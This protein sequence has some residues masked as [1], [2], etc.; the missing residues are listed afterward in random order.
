MKQLTRFSVNYPVTIL[1]L[2]LAI[3]LLGYISFTKIGI[4]LFPDLNN[5]KLYIE[6]SAGERPPEEME[7]LFVEGIESQAIRQSDVTEVSSVTSVGYSLVTIEYSWNK[8]M[9]EAFLDL[10]KAVNAFSQSN[11][12]DEINISQ[13]DPNATPVMVVALE[14]DSISDLNEIRKVADNYIKNELIRLEGVADV[15]LVGEQ[16]SEVVIETNPY[17]LDAFNLTA[18]TISSQIAAYNTNVSG[19]SIEE[20]GTRYSIK[21]LSMISGPDDLRQI[22]VGTY[23]EQLED[24]TTGEI[25]PIYLSDVATIKVVNKDPDSYVRYNG[26]NCIGLSIYKE[27]KFNTVKAVDELKEELRTIEKALPGYKLASVKDQGSFIDESIMEVRDSALYGIILAVIVIFAFLGQIRPT[28]VISIAIPISIVATFV[29]MY[30]LGLSFNIMTLGGLALGAGML[31]DNAIIV[32]ENIYRHMEKGKSVMKAAIK[33]TS[34]VAGAIT[35]STLTTIVVFLPIVYIHGASGELFK[36]QAWTVAFSL[37]SSLFVAILVMPVLVT[38]IF[39]K[40]AKVKRETVQVRGYRKLLEKVLQ[41]RFAVVIVAV[42]LV[43]VSYFLLPRIGSEFMPTSASNSFT[44]DIKLPQGTVLHKTSATTK[45]IEDI[46]KQALPE[47]IE[48]IYT[49]NGISSNS[50]TQ[51]TTSSENEATIFVRLTNL[52]EHQYASVLKNVDALIAQNDEIEFTFEKDETSLQT[53]LGNSDAPVV[54]EVIGDELD[55]ISTITEQTKEIVASTPGLYNIETSIEDGAPEIDVEI[56][57]VR[58]GIYGININTIITQVQNRLEGTDAG[59]FEEDGE[60]KS[61]TIKQPKVSIHELEN[62]EITNANSVYRLTDLATIHYNN[63][64]R[65]IHRRNQNRIGKITASTD[66]SLPLDQ[67]VKELNEKL[68]SVPLP[69][70][71]RYEI[72]GEEVKREESMSNLTF[73]LVLAIILVYMVM[74]AQFE[75]LMNPFVILLTIPLALVGVVFIFLIIGKP[76]NIMAFIGMIML[77]GIAVNDSII[78]IDAINKLRA[79]GLAK[80]EAILQAGQQRIRPIIMTSLTTILALIPLTLGFGSGASLRSPMAWAVIGGLVTSTL[81]TLV[82]IPAVYWILDFS[83]DPTTTEVTK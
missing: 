80:K 83:K 18:N 44:I 58:A 53:I 46:L 82:V 50:Q 57:R 42:A 79:K 72:A 71:Y 59:E 66:G 7:N 8:D 39:K 9:D 10:Q 45:Q 73:A 21:G 55:V 27:P 11:D 47:Q 37:I 70:N 2:V 77:V 51:T 56:D 5:P 69:N 17:M 14:N 62:L 48:A 78:Y 63:L 76:F 30:F 75:S 67:L 38:K 16:E 15:K 54:V 43:A 24:G 60:M 22:I 3:G 65:E 6:V 25:T 61:I 33:G 34:E 64:P 49:E 68:E 81:L 31:V 32:M 20:Q 36:D 1:M 12:V 19:G 29:L 41:Y 52:G 23:T 74:A 35:A 40:N 4:D 13:Y 26:N 28:I